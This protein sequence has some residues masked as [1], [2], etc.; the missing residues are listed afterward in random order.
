[1]RWCRRF[2]ALRTILAFP[3]EKI[4]IFQLLLALIVLGSCSR[5]VPEITR[6]KL[7]SEKYLLLYLHGDHGKLRSFKI[8]GKIYYSL[9]KFDDFVQYGKASWYGKKFHGRKT[10]SGEV[11][12]MYAKTA[13]HKTLPLGI[14]VMVVNRENGRYTVVRI[15]DRGPFVKGRI[16]DLSYSAAKEIGLIGPGVA[17][18]KVVLLGEEVGKWKSATGNN[19][20]VKI[21]DIKRGAFTVQIGAFKNKENA[22]RIADRLKVIY[23]YVEVAPY[24]KKGKHTFYRVRVSRTKTLSEASKVE[25]QLK[26]MGFEGAFIVGL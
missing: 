9:D 5:N 6:I 20:I 12:N 26:K 21:A 2:L 23:P 15:N 19:P 1:M 18:V 4:W 24:R 14:Y 10:S 22:F 17:K 7:P 13:A 11:Y 16:I 25:K 8:N 3:S